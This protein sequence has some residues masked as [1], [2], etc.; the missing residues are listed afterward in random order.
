V[1]CF[2][3]FLIYSMLM[4]TKR[5]VPLLIFALTLIFYS[6]T[7]MP[8]LSWGDGTKLQ[9]DAIM[10]ESFILA[11]MPASEFRPDPYPFAKVG[12]AAWDHPLYIMLG[13]TLVRALPFVDSL[14]LVNFISAVFG[15]AAVMLVFILCQS[16]TGSILA[17]GYASFSLAVSH[18]FW[19]NSS[20][21]EVYTIFV[22]LLLMSLYLFEHY[23]RTSHHAS[24]FLSGFFLG[25][26]ASDHLLAFLAF[27][28][29]ALYFVLSKVYRRFSFSGPRELALPGLGFLAGFLIYIIQFLRVSRSIPVDQI[30]GPVVGSTFLSQ[31]L[32]LT[33]AIFGESLLDYL[34]FLFVQFGPIGIALGLFGIR[35]IFQVSDMHVRKLVALYIVYAI[36]GILY[37]VTDQ[38]A[39]FMTSH[40]FF[41]MAMGIGAHHL[42]S[43]LSERKCL[44]LTSGLALTILATPS[45][46]AALPGLARQAGMDD[47]TL[48]IP[49]IGTG[50]RDG[51]AF[52]INPNKRGDTDAYIFGS[53]VV[54]GLAPNSVVLAEWYT[55]TDEYFVLRYFTTVK[56]SRQDIS[57]YGW[58]SDDP[59]TFDSKLAVGVIED[60]F[61]ERPVYLASLSERFYDASNLVEIYCVAPENNLYRLYPR[62]DSALPC[63]DINSVTE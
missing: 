63:L 10:G 20:T 22:F 58:P 4:P 25:L 60:A 12:V 11:E 49:Q 28:A 30:M 5:L 2:R 13:H 47:A 19:W 9:G 36:F 16:Y 59:F 43:A 27:P 42:F 53:H 46:Y 48:G 35:R 29:L 54:E 32:K 37:K 39:F 61:P 7:L 50:I 51:L 3:G 44:I 38:F 6:F 41:A 55:D 34:L 24:L 26:A 1:P 45:F 21:P 23:E 56:A 15:A 33:P 8:S 62:G 31:L 52:Y 14:W 17:S 57:L 40:V 18:T